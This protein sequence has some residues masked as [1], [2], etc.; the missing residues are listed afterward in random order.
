MDVV[1][2]RNMD[3]SNGLW[4]FQIRVKLSGSTTI[5][6]SINFWLFIYLLYIF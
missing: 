3:V 6:W 5:I 4:T 1:L 2:V